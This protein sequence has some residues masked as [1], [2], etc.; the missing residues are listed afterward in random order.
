M[1]C[2]MNSGLQEVDRRSGDGEVEGKS[3]AC[4]VPGVKR[5][6]IHSGCESWV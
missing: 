1:A 4:V 5:G 2:P 3:G 6:D